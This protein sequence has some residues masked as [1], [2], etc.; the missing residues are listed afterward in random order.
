M[1]ALSAPRLVVTAG[2]HGS[3]STS[4][5]NIVRELMAAAVGAE[6]LVA[7]YGEDLAALPDPLAAERRHVVLKS[8]CGSPGLEWLVALSRAPVIL[9]IRDPRDSAV[10]L[11]ERFGMTLDQATTGLA[12]ECRMAV[13]CADAGHRPL[14]Y[15]DRFFDDPT[16]AVH[17]SLR[18]GLAVNDALCR[19]LMRRYGT[20]GMK[21][22]AQSLDGLPAGRVMRSGALH[23]D[24]VTQIHA[25]HVGDGQVGKWRD[26]L[27]AV[28]RAALSRMFGPF[29]ERF[30]YAAS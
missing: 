28:D 27:P 5:F 2:L 1:A 20:A 14:R 23:Y 18:L 17:L 16:L 26:R 10:S 21:A 24:R 22:F 6:N 3:A 4:L 30:G 8:H 13:R 7:V 12:A 11:M 25:T 29:L 19:D 15:E 9:S